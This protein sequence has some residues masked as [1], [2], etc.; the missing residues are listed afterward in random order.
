MKAIGNEAEQIPRHGIK[1]E[2]GASQDSPNQYVID[3]GGERDDGSAGP[4]GQG[5]GREIGSGG[6]ARKLIWHEAG[7]DADKAGLHAVPRRQSSGQA[8]SPLPINRLQENGGYE[9]R[10]LRHG[11]GGRDRAESEMAPE[12][13]V[14]R[15]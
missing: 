1:A 5:K 11:I 8:P 10:K 9:E 6:A 15:G 7:R 14:A 12:S 13:S 2:C 3:I 4:Y